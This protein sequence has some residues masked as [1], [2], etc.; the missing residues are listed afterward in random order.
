MLG[1]ELSRSVSV[2]SGRRGGA[3]GRPTNMPTDLATA[4]ARKRVSRA[5]LQTEITVL[6]FCLIIGIGLMVEFLA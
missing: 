4:L 5:Y 3:T 1:R 6:L 2:V